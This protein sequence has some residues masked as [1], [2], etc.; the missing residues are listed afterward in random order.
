MNYLI[1]ERGFSRACLERTELGYYTTPEAV[2]S[3]LLDIG[4]ARADIEASALASDSRW[5]G[6]I[7][8]PV[9]DRHARIAT[10]FSRDPLKNASAPDRYLF[11]STGRKPVLFGLDVVLA[12]DASKA[13]ILVEG[14]FD[15]V[16]FH[17]RGMRQF[18]AI[19]G[20]G[21]HLSAKRWD[22]IASLG[23]KEV[24]LLLDNDQGGM[25][26]TRAAIAS[27]QRAKHPPAVYV[28]SPARLGAA[29]DPEEFVRSNGNNAL[30]RLLDC[31]ES[32]AAYR[33]RETWGG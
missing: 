11:L 10:V 9:R 17:S 25:D 27:V 8:C 13:P 5:A 23:I 14:L 21:R 6:R 7:V 16:A 30:L 33:N 15:V 29:K 3:H 24:T 1:Q 2:K 26:G 4:F 19:G 22:R 18:A 31:R 28:I 12:A 32:A 20:H